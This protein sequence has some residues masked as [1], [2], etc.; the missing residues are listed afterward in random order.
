MAGV[1]TG[2][3]RP[4][5]AVIGHEKRIADEDGIGDAIGDIGRR[6]AG[7]VHDLNIERADIEMLAVAKQP[8]EIRAVGLQIVEREDRSKIFLHL[9][10]MLADADRRASCRLDGD[11]GGEVI[12]MRMGLQDHLDA[13]LVLFGKRQNLR[14]AAGIDFAGG[15]IEIQHRVDYGRIAGRRVSDQVADR[16]GRFV[17]KRLNNRLSLH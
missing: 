4:G 10:D 12:R 3:I 2:K 8:V 15:R 9:D 1:A 11:G 16:M 17:E 14:S 13:P 6:M 5:G 7:D